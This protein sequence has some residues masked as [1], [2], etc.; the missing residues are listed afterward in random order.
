MKKGFVLIYSLAIVSILLITIS[1]FHNTAIKEIQVA[2]KE[3]ESLKAFYAADTGVECVRFLQ[4]HY[5]AFS[6]TSPVRS[7]NCGPEGNLIQT[8]GTTTYNFRIEH[9]SNLACDDVS[10]LATRSSLP[11]TWDITVNSS[12]KNSCTNPTVER[13]RWQTQ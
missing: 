9:F 3:G 1:I 2:R 11:N 8:G 13:V 6:P 7:Y 12:G 5:D 10:V 4:D